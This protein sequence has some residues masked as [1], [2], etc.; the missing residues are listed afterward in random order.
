MARIFGEGVTKAEKRGNDRISHQGLNLSEGKWQLNMVKR[1]GGRFL[2]Q[3]IVNAK[4]L[5]VRILYGAMWDEYV[6]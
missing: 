5:G 4:R 3:Q 1:N 2:W 6:Y